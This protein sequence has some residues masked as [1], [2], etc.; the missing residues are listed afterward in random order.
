VGALGGLVGVLAGPLGIFLACGIF[1]GFV[2]GIAAVR[3][4]FPD[5]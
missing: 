5:L 3:A 2:V 1:I 4:R